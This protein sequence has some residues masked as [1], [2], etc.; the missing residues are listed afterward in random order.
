M[1]K[2]T[3]VDDSGAEVATIELDDFTVQI[4]YSGIAEMLE[5]ASTEVHASP[6]FGLSA[7]ERQRRARIL[8]RINAQGLMSELL[9]SDYKS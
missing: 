9:V 4:L 6:Q 3:H 2:V 5:E 8:H 1:V 7:E